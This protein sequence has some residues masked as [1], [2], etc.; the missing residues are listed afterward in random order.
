MNRNN[1]APLAKILLASSSPRRKKIMQGVENTV[2]VFRPDMTEGPRETTES[3]EEYVTRLSREKSEFSIAQG[4]SGTIL[5]ADTTVALDGEIFGKPES[6]T[7]A[8]EMLGKLR[9]RTHH[10]LT[11]V[12]V[13]GQN[14]A[15][16]LSAVK[17]TAVHVREFSEPEM[18]EYL[19]SGIPM[20]RAGAYG[21]QDMPFDPVTSVEGCYL[22]VVG[23]PLCTVADLMRTV[24]AN[25]KLR[26]K[27]RVPYMDRCDSCELVIKEES[28]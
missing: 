14:D 10:V 27:D 13:R 7:Q 16:M 21:V 1:D 9:G 26:P 12:T 20:D 11:G 6:V 4:K 28:V 23:L 24:D 19:R 18:E 22:N 17:S 15:R 8:R 2:E 3:P 25:M 5:T